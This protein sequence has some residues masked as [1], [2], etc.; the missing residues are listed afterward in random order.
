MH[1]RFETSFL[2]IMITGA[3]HGERDGKII[4]LETKKVLKNE[5]YTFWL[6]Y[7][8]TKYNQM[9]KYL[10]EYLLEYCFK[11]KFKNGLFA[12]MLEEIRKNISLIDLYYLYLYFL[13]F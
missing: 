13:M 12:Q 1:I 2:G 4:I 8:T 6:F 10:N 5:E 3:D 11:N 7:C 9:S